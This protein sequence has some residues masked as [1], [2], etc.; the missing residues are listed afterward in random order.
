MLN[1]ECEP[2]KAGRRTQDARRCGSA[3]LAEAAQAGFVRVR[4]DGAVKAIEEVSRAEA[5]AARA[6]DAV[7]DRLVVK[8][9]VRTRLAD[10]VELAMARSGGEIR[11][12]VQRPGGAEEV[13]NESERFSCP[14]C[15]VLYDRLSPASF[16]VSSH[17]GACP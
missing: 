14:D 11:L 13:V 8:E 3:I 10:S 6:I 7:V 17:A 1:A 9:G 4:I 16:S 5:D 12:L 2:Q 15:G